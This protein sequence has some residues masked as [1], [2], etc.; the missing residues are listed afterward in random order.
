MTPE[1]LHNSA[2]E[3]HFRDNFLAKLQS[4]KLIKE[5]ES[6]QD[7]ANHKKRIT[8]IQ[9]L[10]TKN[11]SHFD[12]PVNTFCIRKESAIQKDT[13]RLCSSCNGSGSAKWFQICEKCKGWCFVKQMVKK[14]NKLLLPVKKIEKFI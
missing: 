3:I 2:I 6:E 10:I 14:D 4:E 8:A 5:A 7:E 11:I 9:K 13:Y 1:H 12:Y